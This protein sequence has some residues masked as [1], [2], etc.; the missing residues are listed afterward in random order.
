VLASPLRAS[1]NTHLPFQQQQSQ[2]FDRLLQQAALQLQQNSQG[3]PPTPI[4]FAVLALAN[5]T[6]QSTRQDGSEDSIQSGPDD[7]L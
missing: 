6:A 3:L 7:D 1:S 2:R 5:A 4:N